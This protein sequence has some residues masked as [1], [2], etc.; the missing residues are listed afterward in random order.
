MRLSEESYDIF[1]N[2]DCHRYEANNQERGAIV[3]LGDVE[4]QCHHEAYEKQ[5]VEQVAKFILFHIR[6]ALAEYG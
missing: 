2:L 4:Y 1:S 6:G 3:G 5:R